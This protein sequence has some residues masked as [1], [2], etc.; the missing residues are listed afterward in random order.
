MSKSA[1]VLGITG[2]IFFGYG[3]LCWLIPDPVL[4]L[5]GMQISA[6]SGL[7]EFRAMYGGMQMGFGLWC[8]MALGAEN[9]RIP[10]LWSVLLIMGGLALARVIAIFAGATIS[11]YLSGALIYEGL[12]ALAAAFFLG[13]EGRKSQKI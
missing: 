11:L 1:M 12:T 3:L 13:R 9:R 2:V 5:T 10:G 4:K 8:L 6:A 7:V